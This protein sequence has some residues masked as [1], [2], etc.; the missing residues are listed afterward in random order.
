[1]QK[2]LPSDER[3]TYSGRIDFEDRDHPVFCYCGTNVR[4]RFFGTS[5]YAHIKNTKNDWRN[6]LGW[7][8]DGKEYCL[9]LERDDET[10]R[11]CLAEGLENGWHDLMLFKRQDECHYFVLEGLETEGEIEKVELPKKRLEVIGDSISCGDVVEAVAYEGKLDP[12]HHGEYS[13]AYWS[14]S[15]QLARLLD[16]DIHI[17]SESGIAL[18][19]D[20]G[21][22]NE[23][24]S[25]GTG[26]QG[27]ENCFDYIQFNRNYH[28][29]KKWDFRL[30]TPHVVIVAFGQNDAHPDNYMARDYHGEK[31]V[32]WRKR[33]RAFVE[34]LMNL[35]PDAQIILTTTLLMHEKAWDDAIEEVCQSIHA[36][37][38]TH[39]LYRRNGIATPGHVR[40]AESREMA[41]EMG[42]YIQTLPIRWDE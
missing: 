30:F 42:R 39:F 33:Y 23:E 7:L 31:A 6:Y 19:D 22:F 20:T 27:M 36:D 11:L 40:I 12:E 13:N 18:L 26:A 38:V 24:G 3:L 41:E 10:H 29:F 1:M 2:I 34:K 32:F 16:A 5:V 35:Y 25:N 15:W 4:C 8:M 37:R 14:Y 17:T 21:Y 28:V 9:E